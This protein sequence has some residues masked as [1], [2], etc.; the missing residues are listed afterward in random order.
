MKI[1]RSIV[2]VV[3]AAVIFVPIVLFNWEPNSVSTI[4]NRVLTENPFTRPTTDDLTNDIESYVSDRIGLRD[5]MIL[6]YTVLNDRAFGK[7]VHPSYTYGTDGYVF[8]AG[9]TTED[10]FSDYH[11]AFADM[12]LQL[13]TYCEERGVPFLFVFNPAK[14]AVLT[15]HL[16]SG[17]NYDRTWVDRFF[18]ELDSRGVNYVDNTVTLREA[19][20]N[21]AVVFNKK[22]DANHWND[23]GAFYGTNAMLQALKARLPNTHVNTLEEFAV[24]EQTMTSLPVSN[25]PINEQVP[26]ME[27]LTTLTDLTD[28]YKPSLTMHPSYRTF[29]YYINEQRRAESSPSALVFQG[30]YM[31]NYG[32]K[33][34]Q[35]AFSE[36]VMVHDYQ[37]V[38]DLPYYFNI[39]K[40]DCVIFE[41]AEYT[42]SNG[43]FS[44]ET[45]KNID[46][47]EPSS[48]YADARKQESLDRAKV[49]VDEGEVLTEIVW[50]TET[51]AQR[52]WLLL[53]DE[54]DMKRTDGGYTA[55]VKTEVYKR[56]ADTLS[57][58]TYADGIFTHR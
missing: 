17:I 15:E 49:T 38:M 14:P 52:V 6:S 46:Y 2:I 19:T 35:N 20:A 30:S 1:F 51:E 5:E 29:G 55:T 42:F 32:Q 50:K 22:Y 26:Q 21:G 40:P 10:G 41:V 7:M 23:L 12:V 3:F 48:K 9:I 45:M 8:G 24:G 18:A 16:N 56:Y 13:Q 47:N 43:Y 57:I 44:Y 28:Q 53:G 4:D 11:V 34:L 39:F 31:N 25:F 27:L 37:N 36:Y 33:Y 58:V 54:Y